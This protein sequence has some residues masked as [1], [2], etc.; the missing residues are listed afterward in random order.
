MTPTEHARKLH[1]QRQTTADNEIARLYGLMEKTV[2]AAFAVPL[3]ELRAPSRRT[4]DVAFARQS[5][6]YLAHVALGLSLSMVG[7]IVDRHRTTAAHACLLVEMRRDDPT[8]DQLLDT[9]EDACGDL[10]RDIHELRVTS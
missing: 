8:I 7:R 1:F 10:A 6:M 5:A 9:L 2:A 4:A 3:N